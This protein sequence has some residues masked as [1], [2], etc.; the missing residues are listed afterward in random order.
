MVQYNSGST[1][2]NNDT[3]PLQGASIL[4]I[5][6]VLAERFK[7]IELLGHGGQAQVYRAYDQVLSTDVAL[8]VV[9]TDL[10]LAQSEI[11]SLRNEVLLARQLSHPNI[12]RVYEFY[13][14]DHY[15][16]F[17]MALVDGNPLSDL[18]EQGIQPYQLDRWF[19]QLLD[20]LQ[21]CHEAD[22]V[23]GDI[24]PANLMI[25]DDDQLVVV[26]FGIGKHLANVVQTFGTTEFLAPEVKESGKVSPA[27]DRYA[28]GK[29][30]EMM[31]ASLTYENKPARV[32]RWYRRR[33]Y[34]AVGLQNSMAHQRLS[35]ASCRDLLMLDG[36]KNIAFTFGLLGFALVLVT[37]LFSWQW[38]SDEPV[39][40]VSHSDST[41]I[42]I[43][44]DSTDPDLVNIAEMTQLSLQTQPGVYPLELGQ[45]E[46][47]EGNLAINPAKSK[48]ERQRLA[49]LLNSELLMVIGRRQLGS[50]NAIH[51]LL[52]EAPGDRVLVNMHFD[53]A[54]HRISELPE[55]FIEAIK[56]QIDQ[57]VEPLE[58]DEEVASLFQEIEQALEENEVAKAKYLIEQLK[59]RQANSFWVLRAESL[60]ATS[61]GLFDQA[62][63]ALER[64]MQ[65]YPNRPDLLAE[66]AALAFATN[67]LTESKNYYGQAVAGDPSQAIW[68]FELAKIKIIQGDIRSA[69]N[70]ELLQALV[71]F[72]QSEDVEGQG[73]V[74][75]A[76]GVAH[77]RLAEFSAAI[78]YFSESL[79]YR[80]SER[81][82][83][84]RVTTLSNLAT[85]QA[86]EGDY[87][88]A[89][90]NLKEARELAVALNDRLG[91]AHIENERGLLM[92]EQGLYE[93]ALSH[94]KTALDIR[95]Q[96]DEGYLQSQ[97]INHVAFIHFLLGDFSLAEVYWRQ[98][99]DVLNEMGEVS[100]LHSTQ[101]NL[102]QLLVIRGQFLQAEQLLADIVSHDDLSR[103]AEF[104]TYL[105]LSKLNF[106]QSRVSVAEDNVSEAI[107]IAKKIDDRRAVTEGLVWAAEMAANLHQKDALTEYLQRLEALASEFNKEQKIFY[108]WL[109]IRAMWIADKVRAYD[110]ALNLIKS[111][112]K[113][114]LSRIT[115]TKILSDVVSRFDIPKQHDVWARLEEIVTP[116]MYEAYMAFLAAA[117]TA[118]ARQDLMMQLDRYPQYWRNYEYLIELP[119][120]DTRERAMSSLQYLYSR[121]NNEQRQAYEQFVNSL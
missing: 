12:V 97:S 90:R 114:P 108:R 4:A 20:A 80:T 53:L 59:G 7:I 120:D 107:A 26:D 78:E 94:Y 83:R 103:E 87:K 86:I 66:R 77:L 40:R 5:G 41:V 21:V 16:F 17:T 101:I 51:M 42:A 47:I 70:N 93:E 9:L 76:F 34:I 60:L 44:T 22:I 65:D 18:L 84:E 14:T 121:M 43:S 99:V 89:D 29:L 79:T 105:Q 74:L 19:K 111:V 117:G 37:G 11:D 57:N 32:S 38:L 8:K 49:K 6:T 81:A 67:E 110:E 30:I 102:A 112:L 55:I 35:L 39:E 100:V 3:Q 98:A 113:Q 25:T 71:K 31:L 69:L 28:A 36:S 104:A 2:V 23:H 72:R 52:T 15:V 10:R 62:K 85:A 82:P 118:N 58:Y 54:E 106:A 45:V 24:K 116:A 61:Q 109:K 27:S 56:S 46:R 13:Q 68:W 92:E 73:L 48:S 115:E 63:S 95:L 33:R 1:T 91:I 88:A 119:Y 96:V 64:L 50:N 75:N